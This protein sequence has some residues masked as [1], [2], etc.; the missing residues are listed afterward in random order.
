MQAFCKAVLAG[1]GK[2][3]WAFCD[4]GLERQPNVNGT[5]YKQNLVAENQLSDSWKGTAAKS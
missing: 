5:F 4:A 3:Q 1:A 2:K